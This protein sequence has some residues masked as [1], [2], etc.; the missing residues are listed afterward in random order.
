MPDRIAILG[1]GSL[2]WDKRPEFDQTHDAWLCDGPSLK[3]EFS[4]ISES[5]SGALTLVLDPANGTHCRSAYCRS[6]RTVLAQAIEDLRKRE[7]TTTANIGHVRAGGE[8]QPGE[9]QSRDSHTRA[10]IAA[11]AKAKGFDAV[12][13]TDL[14][15][16]FAAKAGKPFSVD[17]ALAYLAGL[18][19]EGR[20]AA[21]DYI[22]NAPKLVDT[23]LRRR[24]R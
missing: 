7:G 17:A 3:I 24:Y 12:V 8:G 2:L 19:D 10:E 18:P 11:W 15:G 21:A 22:G 5:R 9:G 1:W 6:L 14:Q 23:A 20:R 16:N 4:R 13:W